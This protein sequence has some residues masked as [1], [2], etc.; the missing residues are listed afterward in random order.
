MI[1]D[2]QASF[3]C[4]DVR[5]EASGAHTIVGIIN[6][7][8]APAIPFRVLKLCVWT[9]WTS[10]VGRFTQITRIVGPDEETEIAKATTLFILDNEDGHA[11]NVN[12]FAG[13][14]FKEEG[15]YHIEILLD[16]ELRIRYPLRV[17]VANQ[18]VK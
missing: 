10:G 14:E 13:I 1:P 18:K 6:G 4:E 12:V 17:F 11:I 16:D 5:V 2:L 15:A 3:V 7:V 9:R 8:T